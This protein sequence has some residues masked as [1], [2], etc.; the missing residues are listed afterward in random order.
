MAH[1]AQIDYENRVLQVL[2]VNNEDILDENGDESEELGIK[3]L[4]SVCG[5]ATRWVQ[6]SYNGN[7]RGCYAGIGTTYDPNKDEFIPPS[8]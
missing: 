7:F 5:E 1:F 3:L 4:K 6:T 2:V 8:E